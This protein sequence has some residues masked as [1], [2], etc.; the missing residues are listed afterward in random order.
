MDCE[1]VIV[2]GGPV[3]LFLAAELGQRGISVEVF[4]AKPGTSTHPAANANSARTM[5]HFRRI[6]ISAAVR[7]LGLPCDYAPD[8]AYFTSIAGHEL[9]RLN[10]PSSQAAVEWA[11]AHAFTWAT[12]EPPHRCSQLYV[13]PVLLEAARRHANCRVHFSSK[14]LDFT[15]NAEGVT[16]TVEM[17]AMVD[18]AAQTRTVT[19]RYLIGCDGPRSFVRKS[20]GL[21]YAGVAGEKREFMGGQMDAVYFY[22]PD[23]YR[24][25]PHAPAWQYWTFGAKQRALVIAVDGEGHFIMNVQT[26]EGE[27]LDEADVTQRI[28]E[29]I[30]ADIPFEVKSSSRWTAGFALV[31]EKFSVGRVFLAGDSAHLFT[32]TGGLGYNTG[33]ED[34]AN[35]AWKLEAMV[36]GVAG[37]ALGASYEAERRPAALRNTSFAR[38]FADSIGNVHLPAVAHEAGASGDAARAAVGDY[39][40][41]HATAEFVI[42]GVH[43]GTRYETSPLLVAEA[44]AATPDTANLYVPCARPG[45]RAPHVWLADGSSLYDRFGPGFT[46]LCIAEADVDIESHGAVRNA[47]AMLPGLTVVRVAEAAVADLYQAA[48]VLIRPD[49]HVAWRGSVLG[50][51]FVAAVL[52]TLG[53]RPGETALLPTQACPS[54]A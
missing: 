1:V 51:E 13:E 33:I 10:Q 25:C 38:G 16:A 42:P 15:Q 49:Q 9:A 21:S 17:D 46:L 20:L 12:P 30:G 45:H 2:G 44:G 22:A 53:H 14:V 34:A 18:R 29:A 26:R 35:L 27:S 11:K 3:G 5:E 7:S 24:V 28:A 36:K 41:F 50:D 47:A 54:A 37:D 39:L 32:P 23:I 43:L 8:V 6:G 52:R 40:K 19:A 4:D 31:A 48:F